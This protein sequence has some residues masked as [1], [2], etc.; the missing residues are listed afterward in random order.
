MVREHTLLT[1]AALDAARM[2]GV[3][4]VEGGATSLRPP[5][6]D[7]VQALPK[8]GGLPA[9]ALSGLVRGA[10]GDAPRSNS[11]PADRRAGHEDRGPARLRRPADEAPD[12]WRVARRRGRPDGANGRPGDQPHHRRGGRRSAGGRRPCGAR[13]PRRLPRMARHGAREA[14]AD[15][16]AR[17]RADRGR[18][19]AA[20]EDR[21]AR[22]RQADPR[23]G[24][25]RPARLLGSV[26]LLPGSGAGDRRPG[27]GDA[28][29]DARLRPQGADGRGRHDHPLE[30]PA[31]HRLP[32]GSGGAGGG[33]HRRPQG[34]RAGAADLARAGTHLP[35]GGHAAGGVQRGARPGRGGRRCAGR[36]PRRRQGRVHRIDRDRPHRDARRRRH[37]QAGLA[38]AGRQ[39]AIGRV[40]RRRPRP[41]GDRQRVRHL[42]GAGR[43]L[44]G[45]LAGAGGAQRPRRVRRP[46][47]RAGT[48]DPRRPPVQ[49]VDRSW[50]P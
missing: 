48:A 47:R 20:G 25:G 36:A 43:G 5:A 46:L 14:V 9:P 44:L 12:R 40:R 50:A 27:A 24:A 29:G 19:R 2:H 41:G 6:D 16:A 11:R 39:V 17:G 7:V 15:P 26:P 45:R 35:G 34:A 28:A 32:Q 33:Q 8:K 21:V 10:G 23:G 1:D 31:A 3:R 37:D 4:L 42:P 49:V 18:P 22:R 13:G 30:L 38:R